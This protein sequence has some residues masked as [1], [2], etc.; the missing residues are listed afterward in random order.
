MTTAWSVRV[1]HSLEFLQL[2]RGHL[3]LHGVELVPG[4]GDSRVCTSLEI[5]SLDYVGVLAVELQTSGSLRVRTDLL[6]E[7]SP[8]FSRKVHE[9]RTLTQLKPSHSSLTESMY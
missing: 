2:V 4:F 8:E 3:A 6:A 7:Q 1:P 9:T 5:L